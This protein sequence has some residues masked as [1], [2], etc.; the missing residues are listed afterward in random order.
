MGAAYTPSFGLTIAPFNKLAGN[1]GDGFLAGH[2]ASG[3]KPADHV[4]IY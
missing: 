2:M 3:A 1:A 4:I